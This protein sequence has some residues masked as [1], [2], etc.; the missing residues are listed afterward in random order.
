MYSC[1]QGEWKAKQ[2]PNPNYKGKWVHPETDNPE[3]SLDPNLYQHT[4]IGA[5]GFDLWQVKSGTIFDNILITDDPKHAEEIGNETW[6]KTKVR[7]LVQ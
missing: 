7:L 2:V 3:Y 6:G 4:N 5:I 1:F